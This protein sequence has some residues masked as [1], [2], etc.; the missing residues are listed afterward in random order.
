MNNAIQIEGIGYAYHADKWVFRGCNAHIRVG[1]VCAILGPNGS[2]KTTLLRMLLG[3][4]TPSEGHISTAGKIAY[5]PQLFQTSFT[6]TVLDMVLMGRSQHIGLFSQ[7]SQKDIAIALQSLERFE[8]AHL[9]HHPF[10]HLSGGERQLAIFAR[11]L[12]AQANL[13]VLDE[14]A[15]ALDLKHQSRILYWIERLAAEEHITIVFTTHHPNHALAVASSALLM[16]SPPVYGPALEVLTE[17]NLHALYGVDLRFATIEHR[18]HTQK[19][20]VPI[21][22]NHETDLREKSSA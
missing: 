3:M 18:G 20:L 15:S 7:P 10:S 16:M 17:N 1:E 8:I 22:L 4:L 21:L 12:A 5:V 13:L 2:G 11:A 14:P 19:H 6:Y 9:A